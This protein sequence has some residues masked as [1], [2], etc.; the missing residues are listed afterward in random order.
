MQMRKEDCSRDVRP[1]PEDADHP[2]AGDPVIITQLGGS[3]TVMTPVGF[4]PAST[5]RTLTRSAKQS[6]RRRDGFEGKTRRSSP[7][8]SSAPVSTR[9]SRSTSWTSA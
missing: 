5:A 3:Y 4:P 1:D 7:G 2:K 6:S 9:R 8:I